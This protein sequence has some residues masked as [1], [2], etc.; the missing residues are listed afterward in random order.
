MK[1]ILVGAGAHARQVLLRLG[2]HWDVVVVDI[3]ELRFERFIEIRDFDAVV[4]DGSSA[5]VL[6]RAGV[7]QADAV[8]AATGHDDVNLACAKIALAEGVMRVIA[9]AHDPAHVDEYTEA[10]IHVVTPAALAARHIEVNLEPRRVV[11]TAFAGGKAEA[12]EFYI[13]PDTP[14]AGKRLRALHSETWVIAAVLRGERLIIP[15]GGTQI[16]AGDRVTVVGEAADFAAIVAT[17]TSGK[18]RF[19]EA[20]GRRVAVVIDNDI[21]VVTTGAAA[22]GMVRST[23]ADSLLVVQRDTGRDTDRQAELDTLIASLG[24]SEDGIDIEVRTTKEKSLA[25]GLAAIAS[26]ESVGIVVAPPPRGSRIVARWRAMRALNVYGAVGV[27]VLFAS[28]EPAWED[29]FVLSKRTPAG[30]AAA[31]V[32]ID[33]AKALGTDLIGVGVVPPIFVTGTDE[34]GEARA[35]AAWLREEASVQGV[36]VRR[37]IRRGNPVKVMEELVSANDL[38]VLPMPTLPLSLRRI[39]IATYMLG[40]VGGSLLVVPE[41]S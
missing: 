10:G 31:R 28:E 37:K 18:S 38:L 33:L 2:P 36:G 22:V 30:E 20:Y 11:S 34:I 26:E 1:V 21:D 15:H 40:R 19:P 14:V 7:G 12:I 3:D 29:T 27:P 41:L 17:F 25:E 4:G 9:I 5:L 13:S 39:G 6:K 24:A 16:L 8:V 32:A 35:A 23:R